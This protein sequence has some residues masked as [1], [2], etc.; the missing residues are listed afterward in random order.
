[1]SY[2]EYPYEWWVCNE[3][4]TKGIK[5]YPPDDNK[6]P[7]CGSSDIRPGEVGDFMDY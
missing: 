5:E 4:G 7:E 1:M 2:G 3:C 6:C